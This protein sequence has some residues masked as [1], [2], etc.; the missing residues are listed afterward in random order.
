M[1][2][3]A[4]RLVALC[5]TCFLPHCMQVS[6]GIEL[7][8]A[9][10]LGATPSEIRTDMGYGVRLERAYIA[11][12]QVELIRCDNFVSDL[13]QIIGPA[14]AR[15][16]QINTPTSLGVPLV[17]DLMESTGTPIFAG[18][19]RPPPGRYCG[20]RVMG[21]PADEDAEGLTEQNRDMMAH[22]VLI[23][24]QA[25][26]RQSGDTWPLRAQIWEALPCEIRLDQPLVFDRPVLESV[27]IAIDQTR[28]FDGIDFARQ[29]SSAVQQQIRENVRSSVTA[30]RAYEE[31]GLFEPEE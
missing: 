2:F 5:C 31:D 12:G 9:Y 8:V 15:A 22:S 6:D 13:W 10:Q 16:H 25:E 29:D 4:L 11:I 27:S 30:V 28:W 18:T 14:R 1:R 7:D 24:G 20:I 23:F 19:I 21:M 26:D 3:D 17:L